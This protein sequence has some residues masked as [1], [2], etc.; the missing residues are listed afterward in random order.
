MTIDEKPLEVRI[1]KVVKSSQLSKKSTKE[2]INEIIPSPNLN[3]FFNQFSNFPIYKRLL[4]LHRFDLFGIEDEMTI[5][6]LHL[7]I[8]PK[9]K[10]NVELGESQSTALQHLVSNELEIFN[11]YKN[12]WEPMI[13]IDVSNR[14]VILEDFKDVLAFFLIQFIRDNPKI[15]ELANADQ[16]DYNLMKSVLKSY[17]ETINLDGLAKIGT[18]FEIGKGEIDPIIKSKV[19]N[20]L[21]LFV[22]GITKNIETFIENTPKVIPNIILSLHLT[23]SLWLSNLLTKSNLSFNEYL[24]ILDSLYRYNI[25]KNKNTIFWCENCSIE[26]PSLTQHSGKIAP[27]KISR[28]KCLNCGKPQSYGSIF[29]LNDTLKEAILSKDGLLSVYFGWLLQKEGI[30]YEVGGYSGKYEN[31]FIIKKSILVECKMFKSEKDTVAILSEIDSSLSQIKKHIG[32]LNSE[33]TKIKEA[34]LLW[35]RNDDEEELQMKLQSRYKELFTKYGFNIIC[36]DEIENFVNDVK[37]N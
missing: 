18:G 31:D 19:E 8:P 30:E 11:N 14:D 16:F 25:I 4:F 22:S 10:K 13:G 29:S 2:L 20:L 12:I 21:L 6:C 9:I 15:K 33:G 3:S 7:C 32:A 1:E 35:N 24:N 23:S 5:P 28:S 27:S 17:K 37:A 34:Y 26:S 36:P